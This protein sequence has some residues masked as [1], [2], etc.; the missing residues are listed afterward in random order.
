MSESLKCRFCY[1][2]KVVR[3]HHDPMSKGEHLYQCKSCG[4]VGP[5]NTF[6]EHLSFWDTVNRFA[7]VIAFAIAVF[8]L[9]SLVGQWLK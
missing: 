7:T 6:F 1:S 5:R 8:F 9:L 4:C 3:E 2:T